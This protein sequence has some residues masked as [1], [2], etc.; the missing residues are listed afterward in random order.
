MTSNGTGG[1][2]TYT[3][4]GISKAPWYARWWNALI[5]SIRLW[6]GSIWGHNRAQIGAG[7]FSSFSV[8]EQISVTPGKR[9]AW[10]E[11]S[12]GKIRKPL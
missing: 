4:V 8:G 12:I 11:S 6:I 5:H 9:H 2:V 1:A 3:G 7:V 10:F